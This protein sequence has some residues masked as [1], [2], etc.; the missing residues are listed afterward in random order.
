MSY[1][2][3]NDENLVFDAPPPEAERAAL[4]IR[5]SIASV[6]MSLTEFEKISA[7]LAALRTEHPIDLVFDVSTTKGM[8][9]AIAHRAAWRD[10]RITVEKFR[11]AAKA[12]VLTLGKDIDARAAWLTDQLLLGETPA[13]EQIKAEEARKAQEKAD[14]EAA[15]FGRVL[16]I[17]EAIAEFGMQATDGR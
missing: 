4:S 8:A 13:H 3:A 12:P 16:A 1:D 11:K 7:G 14:R 2:T 6:E 10:P 9:E 17:Q 15:E 5:R